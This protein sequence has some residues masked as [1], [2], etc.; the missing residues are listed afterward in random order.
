[1]LITRSRYIDLDCLGGATINSKS[2]AHRRGVTHVRHRNGR[3]GER[4]LTRILFR[5][6]VLTRIHSARILWIEDPDDI[7]GDWRVGEYLFRFICLG[8]AHKVPNE[9]MNEPISEV[10]VFAEVH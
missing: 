7:P 2:H 3:I 1:M 9:G 10:V 8:R 4:N 5:M 6:L